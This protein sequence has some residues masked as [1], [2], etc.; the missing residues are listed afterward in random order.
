MSLFCTHKGTIGTSKPY[1]ANQDAGSI[2]GWIVVEN[3]MKEVKLV[4]LNVK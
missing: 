2:Y 4:S 1:I 3:V